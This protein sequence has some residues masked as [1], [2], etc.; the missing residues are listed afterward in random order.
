MKRSAGGEIAG[1]AAGETAAAMP[2]APQCVTTAI[3]S[4]PQDRA[5]ETAAREIFQES[6]GET[7]AMPEAPQCV[8]TAISTP[9]DQAHDAAAGGIG[10]EYEWLE[11]RKW[12]EHGGELYSRQAAAKLCERLRET[13]ELQEIIRAH[14]ARIVFLENQNAELE[15]ANVEITAFARHQQAVIT[16]KSES[17]AEPQA[18]GNVLPPRGIPITTTTCKSPPAFKT[19]PAL[20]AKPPF[21]PGA[22]IHA[23]VADLRPMMSGNKIFNAESVHAALVANGYGAVHENSVVAKHGNS[24][25]VPEKAPPPKGPPSLRQYPNKGPAMMYKMPPSKKQQQYHKVS[26]SS[27]S[28]DLGERCSECGKLMVGSIWTTQLVP[29][30]MMSGRACCSIECLNSYCEAKLDGLMNAYSVLWAAKCNL[31]ARPQ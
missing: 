22:S 5:H 15:S 25:E 14:E 4:T 1:E 16:A 10:H 11:P 9:Q 28:S 30:N 21:V 18:A 3:L 20:Q 27:S 2:E 12:S 26:M 29:A 8:T 31:A 24:W 23:L 19:P 7:A 6:A 13:E 17:A